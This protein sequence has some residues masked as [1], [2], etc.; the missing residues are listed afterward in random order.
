M[1]SF[2]DIKITGIDSD[3]PPR[4]RKEAYIDLFFR[5][6]KKVPADWGAAFNALGRKLTPSPKIDKVSGE[7][8]E[9][10]VNDMDLIAQHLDQIKQAVAECNRAYREKLDEQARALAASNASLQGQ[11]GEQYRLNQIIAALEF[12]T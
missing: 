2:I 12:D 8:I 10:Y 7:F 3:R 4:M 1:S 9:T 11:D 6:S 5:L